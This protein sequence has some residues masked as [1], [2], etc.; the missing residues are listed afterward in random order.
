VIWAV[1]KEVTIPP[2][3]KKCYFS[4]RFP[5][6]K[7]NLSCCVGVSYHCGVETKPKEVK[8]LCILLVVARTSVFEVRGFHLVV[9]YP[10]LCD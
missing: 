3:S 9:G 6:L 2:I 1:K 8:R 4:E 7:L 5:V 10:A